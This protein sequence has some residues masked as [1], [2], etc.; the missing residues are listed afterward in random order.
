MNLDDPKKLDAM[1]KAGTLPKLL[2]LWG[3]DAGAVIRYQKKLEKL[4]IGRA[5]V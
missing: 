5:H 4:E 1:A 2:L 3:E